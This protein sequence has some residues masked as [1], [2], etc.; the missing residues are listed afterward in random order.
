M[1]ISKRDYAFIAV[2]AVVLIVFFAISGPEKTKKVPRDATHQ[3]FYDMMNAG[4]KKSEVDPL[5]AGCH[6]GVKLKFPDK[7]PAKP[8]AG[9][10][11][12]LFCHKLHK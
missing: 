12:C 1:T 4:K 6:D 9:P 10:M 5:C 3:Q 7:H 2:V 11:R 8:G